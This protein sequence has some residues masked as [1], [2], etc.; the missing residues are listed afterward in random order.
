[1]AANLTPQFLKAQ[2]EYRRAQTTEEEIR[3]LEIMLKEIPKHK[4][5][6]KMQADLK[7]KLSTAKK[8]LQ[9][10]KSSP[11]KTIGVRI[12]RQGAGTAIV[13]GGPNAGKSQLVCSLTRATPEVAE[14]PFTTRAPQQGMMPFEDVMVQLVDTPPVT[15]DYFE[16]YM[17]GLV[18]GA[19][20][21]LLML[22]LGSDDGVEQCQEV[23]ERF[24]ETKTRLAKTTGLDENDVGLSYTATILVPNKIDL[25]DAEAR[26]ELFEELC[27]VDFPVCKISATR[28]DGLEELAKRIYE[29]LDV[30][31][32]YTKQPKAK[33]ADMEK[34]F[35]IRRG[36]TILDVAEQIHKDIAA[37]FKSAR[38][39]GQN[40]HDGTSVKDDYLPADRDIVEIHV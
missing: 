37:N 3:C 34:P 28:G 21:V 36:G 2:E 16:S 12:P 4:A 27:P 30:V 18:R 6:E 25:P 33:E 5:S 24:R 35:T 29:T 17:H 38:V 20:V 31:R 1:M 7:S 40:V 19:D 13:L 8:E 23:L 26:W 39:W 14:Y 10:E 11:K 32:V 9:K 15:S 22:D